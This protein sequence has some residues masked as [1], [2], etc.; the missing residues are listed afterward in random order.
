M[1][2]NYYFIEG[3][4]EKDIIGFN[5]YVESL[6]TAINNNASFIGLI[7]EFGT[8]KSSLIKMLENSAIDENKQSKIVTINLWNCEENKNRGS[9]IDIHRIFLHQ[10]IDELEVE[11]K[12]YYKKKI[13]RKY[14]LF[15]IKLGSNSKLIIPLLLFLILAVFERLEFI[16]LL[17]QPIQKVLYYLLIAVLIIICLFIYKPLISFSRESSNTNI[18][19][20]DTKDL[21]SEIINKFFLKNKNTKLIIC[22]EE[23]DRFTDYNTVIKHIREFYK[24]YKLNPADVSFIVAIKSANSLAAS[25]KKE[26]M[27]IITNKIK[28]SYEKVFDFI[29][30]LNTINVQDYDYVLMDLLEEKRNNLPEG[31][32]FP[33]VNKL[34][35][36]RYLFLGDNITIR[37]IKHR[38]NFAISLY[39]SVKESVIENV[40]FK[41]C[42]YISY[43]EDEHNTLYGKL[44]SNSTIINDTLLYFAKN[45]N[46]D[47]LIINGK[48]NFF[49]EPEKEIISDGIV[50][51]FIDVDYMYY[52]FKFPKNKR[53][54]T[55][56]EIN[57]Y[58][59]IFFNKYEFALNY[60][61]NQLSDNQIR[62]IMKKRIDENF[63]PEVIFDYNRL[64]KIEY[65]YEEKCFIDTLTEKYDL[66]ANYN[67]FETLIKK[68]KTA[69]KNV[70]KHACSE[71]FKIKK[72]K[73][74][75]LQPDERNQL[76][77]KLVKLFD[78]DSIF[79]DYMFDENSD[80][81][82]VEEISI[83]NDI[84][85]INKLTNNSKV[86]QVYI[87]ALKK[88][89]SKE[90][91]KTN[92]IDVL[93]TLADNPIV[94]NKMYDEV[95]SV[96]NFK[97]Y[98]LT[99]I[100]TK[101]IF[102]ISKNKLELG[103]INNFQKFINRL[104]NYNKYLDS[105]YIN[106]IDYNI[107]D[108]IEKYIDILTKFD[109][110]SEEGIDIIDKCN[111]VFELPDKILNKL[112]ERKHY[113]TYVISRTL[114]K[115]KFE[116]E[117]EKG[118]D[119]EPF[120]LDFF[121]S[122]S[123]WKYNVSSEMTN[124]LY[125]NVNFSVLSES[126]LMVFVDEEQ[127]ID[128]IN[129]VVNTDNSVF[130]NNYISRIKKIYKPDRK[131]ILEKI[132]T[133]HKKSK[134]TKQARKN[135]I[136]LTKNKKEKDLFDG[137][138]R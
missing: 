86:N 50:K 73:I 71:Y 125:T 80:L 106:I 101:N 52:F 121:R 16:C 78:T 13:N 28:T 117:K 49:D 68:I 5:S 127:K 83:I 38:Y 2:K 114:S 93:K 128:I 108:E 81:I 21:Y 100:D 4:T 90:L 55:I 137:R 40:K 116:Y 115:N 7:S 70:Y 75:N 88:K 95:F 113:L 11:P 91:Y 8:G 119:L 110:I 67:K 129:K 27:E 133:Y 20:N 17:H 112:Y 105:E 123:E 107:P 122:R 23:L 60:S 82:T 134:L 34:G 124:Y 33:D 59:A 72:E 9:K 48:T 66:I 118:N 89:I 58:N 43:L 6:K 10:L 32:D 29:L 109:F 1:G 103:N 69:N 3:S 74:N 18:D 51:K 53:A 44:V 24:F 15:D 132:S 14:R 26:E 19:E 98:N 54:Y 31:I 22:L 62:E 126:Q 104:N 96:I 99:E 56:H 111:I 87:T 92:I 84:K 138:K 47:N 120:Y 39:Q 61:L 102:K 46:L 30:N 25:S 136:S 135:I 12:E 77:Y 57:L 37:D 97:Q 76:R 36:W 63:L 131:Q 130:I 79:F 85:I 35:A 64:I 65:D 42:L 94:D 45:K 41:T